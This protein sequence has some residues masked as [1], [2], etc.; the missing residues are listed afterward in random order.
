MPE[1]QA[2]KDSSM[3]LQKNMLADYYEELSSATEQG[4]KVVYT[5]VPGNLTEL[6][7]SFDFLPV[8]P[9]INAL[10]SAMRKSSGDFIHAAK[11]PGIPKMSARM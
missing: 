10:Q 6:M 7:L 4:K 1:T 9:E 3:V 8:Y 2:T 5:F 11:K